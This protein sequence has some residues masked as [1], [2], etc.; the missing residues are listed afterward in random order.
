MVGGH[1][2]RAHQLEV[3]RGLD[4]IGKRFQER[5][6]NDSALNVRGA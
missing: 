1:K 5:Q 3:L 4:F 2:Q 6:V